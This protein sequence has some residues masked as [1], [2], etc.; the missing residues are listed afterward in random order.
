MTDIPAPSLPTPERKIIMNKNKVRSKKE[1]NHWDSP[2]IMNAE[3]TDTG[4]ILLDDEVATIIKK[5]AHRTLWRQTDDMYCLFAEKRR[6]EFVDKMKFAGIKSW[7]SLVRMKAFEN[8]LYERASS[9]DVLDTSCMVKDENVAKQ[10]KEQF[11]LKIY[12]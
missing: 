12:P 9:I 3:K 7:H 6:K 8:G 2:L 4:K 11:T 5:H 1:N 10:M